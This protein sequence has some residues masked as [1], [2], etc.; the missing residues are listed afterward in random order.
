MEK[1]PN[2]VRLV[3][4]Q[5]LDSC[6]AHIKKSVKLTCIDSCSDYFLLG[7]ST[8][9]LYVFDRTTSKFVQLLSIEDMH[10]PIVKLKFSPDGKLLAIATSKPC[11]YAIEFD[12]T[13]RIKTKVWIYFL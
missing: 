8:G 11:I 10:E 13:K 6:L 7:A 9:S 2:P 4:Y 1:A 12:I 5:H 3:S